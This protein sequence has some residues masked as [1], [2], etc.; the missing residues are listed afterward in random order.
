[1]SS[2]L[3][4]LLSPAFPFLGAVNGSLYLLFCELWYFFHFSFT[5]DLVSYTCSHLPL[6]GILFFVVSLVVNKK[7][8]VEFSKAVGNCFP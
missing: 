3:I 5:I 6:V 4:P 8:A 7:L 2:A 1:M